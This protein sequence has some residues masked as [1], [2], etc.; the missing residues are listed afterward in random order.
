M[1]LNGHIGISDLDIFS[2]VGKAAAHDEVLPFSIKDGQLNVGGETSDFDGTLS[3]EFAKV[4]VTGSLLSSGQG[5]HGAVVLPQS[6]F[7]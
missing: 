3:V 1:I 2:S 6:F 4:H 7:E 5:H